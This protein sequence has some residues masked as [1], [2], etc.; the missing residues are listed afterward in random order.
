[1]NLLRKKIRR[2]AISFLALTMSATMCAGTVLMDFGGRKSVT[3]LAETA[4]NVKFTDITGQVDTSSIVESNFNSSVQRSDV[5]TYETRTVIISLDGN[6]L[7]DDANGEYSVSEYINTPLG[8]QSLKRINSEQS[9]FLTSLSLRGI[10]YNL[11]HT[12]NSVINAVAIEIDTS[13]VAQIKKMGGVSSAVISRTYAAPKLYK[14]N[15]SASSITNNTNVYATGIYDSSA[16]A[17]YEWGTGAGTVVAILDTGIDYTHEAF[18][19]MPSKLGMD[20]NYVESIFGSTTA[21]RRTVELGGTANVDDVYVS[22]KV[23]FAYDYADNDF[24]VYPSYSNHGAHVAGIVGGYDENGYDRKIGNDV[25]H[26]D[27]TFKGVATEAQLV[28]CKTFTD[29]LESENIG[30]ALT[31]DILAALDDCVALG[32]DVINMSL[33]TTSGF[34]TTDDGD[35]EGEMMDKTYKSIQSQGISL[36]CAASN[37]Y[38]SGFGSV[39]GTNLASNPDSATVGSPSTFYSAL[40]VASI[41]GQRSP[42]MIAGD[43]TDA[44]E[45]PVFYE[46]ARDGNSV[47]YDFDGELFAMLDD[48]TQTRHT[49][50]YV[51]VGK[52]GAQD[53]STTVKN[54]LKDS[55]TGKSLG[56]LALIERGNTTFL[57]KIELAFEMG[58]IGAIIYNNVSGTIRMSLGDIEQSRRIPAVSI[59]QD[60][61]NELVSRA[62]SGTGR[63]LGKITLDLSLNAG[64]FMSDFSSWGTTPNLK[65]KPEITAHGGEIISTVPGGYDAQSGTSM[66]SP[67]MAGVTA[68]VRNYVKT[69]LLP[70]DATPVQVTQLTNQLLLSTATT[71]VDPYGLLYSPRKQGAGL[72][73]LDNI[74]KTK[75]YL[76]TD[77]G[78]GEYWYN[79][80]DGRPKV[81]LG[82][83]KNKVGE[84][85]FSFKIKNFGDSPLTFSLDTTFMTESLSSDKLAV[86]EKAY[87]LKD[88]APQ[89][90]VSGASFA[91]GEITVAGGQDAK[92]TVT[93]K[94]SDAE[95]KYIEQSF[96]NGMFVEGFVSLKGSGEQCDLSIPFLA[97]YGDWDNLPMLDYD[98]F[99]IAESQRDK[100]V[101]E[102]DKLNPT[103]FATQAYA[104]Y[105]GNKYVIPIGNYVYIQ[106]ELEDQ[107]YTTEDHGAISRFD[108]IVSEEGIGNY[109]T[110]NQIRCL[111]AGLLR[112]AYKVEWRMYDAYTGELITNSYKNRISKAYSNGGAAVP[113]FVELKLTPDELG[114]VNNGK[115]RMEF[116]FYFNENSVYSEE[117]TFAFSFY[118]DYD[119]PVL[120]DAR[121]RYEDYKDG[122]KNKQNIYLELDIYDN[123]YAQSVMLAYIDTTGGRREMKLATEYFT[124]VQN[125]VKNGV[126]TVSIDVT[127]IWEQY[128]KTAGG[129][130]VQID[131]Y[132]LNHS[133]YVLGTLNGSNIGEMDTA[134]NANVTPATFELA[135]GED[136]I[137]VGVNETHTVALE[138]EGNA[139]ISNFEWTA[140]NPYVKVKN[141]EIVG[142]RT[143]G[144]TP[145]T[146]I[147]SNRKGVSRTIQVTVVDNGK[148]LGWPSISFDVIKNYADAL[149]KA[150]GYVRVHAGKD[151]ALSVLTDPWY[152]P[153]ALDLVWSTDN[154]TVATVDQSGN[155]HTI[156]K[157]NAI[158]KATIKGTAYSASVLL[159]VQDEFTIDSFSLTE[160]HGDGVVKDGQEGVVEIPDGKN[161]MTIGER[162]FAD[163]TKITKVIIPKSVTEIGE[164]AFIGCTNLKEVCFVSDADD[165]YTAD[166]FV[167]ASGLK[168]IRKYAF[169]GCSSLET[170][171][172]RNCKVISIAH[173]A[174]ANCVNLKQIIKSTA[175][176]TAY[177]RAFMGCSS[178][179]S[180]DLSGLHVAGRNVFSGCTSLT[181]ITTDKFTAIGDNMFTSLHYVYQEM[182]FDTGD[183]NIRV[184]DY[185][186]CNKLDNLVIKADTVGA[187]AFAGCTGITKVEFTNVI[188]D[189]PDDSIVLKISDNAFRNCTNLATVQFNGKVKSIGAYAFANTAITSV[190]LPDGL[191][192]LGAGAFG[193]TNMP[194][195]AGGSDYQISGDF[196]LNKEGTMLLLYIG[197]GTTC[198]IPATVTEIAA[199]AFAESSI[200]SLTIPATVDIIGEG[201]FQNSALSSI[202]IEANLA[203]IPA[204]A[205]FG[206]HI[207]Q[208]T[209]PSTVTYIGD[210]AFANC[211]LTT[212]NFSP[213]LGAE[214]GNY[215]FYN[216]KQLVNIALDSKIS[217]LGDGVFG[218]CTALET[219]TLP[220]LEYLGAYTFFETPSLK[221]V[222]FASGAKVTGNYTF[223]TQNAAGRANLTAVTLGSS[224]TTIG[225]GAFYNCAALTS[226]NLGGAEIIEASAFFGCTSLVTVTGLE[227][228]VSIGALAFYNCGLENLN[229]LNA[230][231][232]GDGAFMIENEDSAYTSVSIP[233]AVTIG[234]YTFAGGG[235]S[236]I[237]LPAT[238]VKIGGGAFASSVNL[239]SFTID[240]SNK[241]FFKDADGVLYRYITDSV[242]ELVAYPAG[243]TAKTLTDDY[244]KN[245]K[246]Y[247]VLDGTIS[248]AASAFEGLKTG[249]IEHIVLP[250][251]LKIIGSSAFFNSGIKEYRFESINAPVL[252][253]EYI[254]WV[255][256]YI[257]DAGDVYV[258]YFY[259]NFEDHFINHS[260]FGDG[261]N[262]AQL[263]MYR[264]ENGVG[265]DILIYAQYFAKSV[266]T[267]INI[268]DTTREVRDLILT[269]PTA[270]EVSGWNSS[271]KPK[272][273]VEEFSELVKRIR[274]LFNT[275][276]SEDQ[277]N[278][279]GEENINHLGDVE[280]ALR[281]VKAAYNIPV[282]ITSVTRVEGSYKSVYYAGEKFDMKGLQVIVTYDDFSTE[283]VGADKLTLVTTEPLTVY[284]RSVIVSYNGVECYL[285]VT[286]NKNDTT[287][288]VGGGGSNS[289]CNSG[290]NSVTD[291]SD[292]IIITFA[293]LGALLLVASTLRRRKRMTND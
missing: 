198:E 194:T 228:V 177:D 171:D 250:Y 178:L 150:S 205:F 278:L 162:A 36:I 269:L 263:T 126:T 105:G 2:G 196:I 130:I 164:Y 195:I 131:D 208:I 85:T 200:T 264:P 182:D 59:T 118:L 133:T 81:E 290:C 54:L 249:A 152:Y 96:K 16:V 254:D 168:L 261:F 211:A 210:Y 82:A 75:A 243:V 114:L 79:E 125:A 41:N 259:A 62:Q 220:A 161:I 157:G 221:T 7:I 142:V 116:D 219:V 292:S 163:N 10:K 88:I 193:G 21:F 39:F 94:L 159:A 46:E 233:K 98:C 231:N 232:I 28:I 99:D 18:Q 146:V 289:G 271:N 175:I 32:V 265:Y 120:Q 235:E 176:G 77:S 285:V 70:A 69:Q 108:E 14:E 33:G 203:E 251:T 128:K 255:K 124:P 19:T 170:L 34:T 238:L 277:L 275:I 217:V 111:Y 64:P 272:S 93:V 185:E 138:Y 73:S 158:I 135:E 226:I 49:F 236:T 104:S 274:S 52:G 223:A 229:L 257:E 24:D 90:S 242:Y 188:N 144:R 43:G 197:S 174:F 201:A 15:S 106:D 83:D 181:S 139:N 273:E 4:E 56:R 213:E 61:G 169:K 87:L 30:G 136:K 212:F 60:A 22:D 156:T 267:G 186:A 187:N 103:V 215:V 230:E 270:S 91:G 121:I 17:D 66:A 293:G 149:V 140:N 68:L 179:E 227:N 11:K 252:F 51:V 113:G 166:G 222:T 26:Y 119:A 78:C 151:I 38:S 148:T 72:A 1:M 89:Y 262:P 184:T 123:H 37:D 112:N 25:V 134:L 209:L 279:L 80:L 268:D 276:I 48:K 245:K 286:V 214:L 76:Y 225:E 100:S 172:L 237:A 256:Q 57:E 129:L 92:I 283:T 42:Y 280:V 127:D 241:I 53:Y 266:T 191:I 154:P 239:T 145:A 117:N 58:A 287:A 31:E 234:N 284:D 207:S 5:A 189:T 47:E 8:R 281:A 192:S 288:P 143:T 141:G 167:S 40:S 107:I 110:A 291:N 153:N 63:R 65:I 248:V 165:D 253:T 160:Y 115:Y 199:N 204:Y 55:A 12:Y 67:N 183:W 216:C 44:D 180:I 247:V 84:Y 173:E 95:K 282:S 86:A 155:V 218:G 224:L 71:V 45:F 13:N 23:P 20:K 132:A 35:D 74:V 202:T 27:E 137:T 246:T 101:E 244:A 147:V 102:K 260:S 206:T 3:A 6:S 122:N 9:K 50:E 190:T 109:Y 29:N 258:G 97:F 240:A